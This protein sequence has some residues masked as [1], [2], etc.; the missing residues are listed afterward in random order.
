MLLGALSLYLLR[1]KSHSKGKLTT[2]KTDSQD[3][4]NT[5]I[6]IVW[7]DKALQLALHC[8]LWWTHPENW[9]CEKGISKSLQGQKVINGKGIISEICMQF[10][11][12]LSNHA[13]KLEERINDKIQTDRKK[14]ST[15]HLI[16]DIIRGFSSVYQVPCL[17]LTSFDNGV[18]KVRSVAVLDDQTQRRQ[19]AFCWDL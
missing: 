2:D 8:L 5:P 3:K 9:K 10:I 15:S 14:N 6:K 11:K 7:P 4:S 13:S 16:G 19:S 1:F 12:T 18:H 17:L